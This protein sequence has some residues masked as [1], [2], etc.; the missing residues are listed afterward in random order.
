VT[1]ACGVIVKV[2]Q[3]FTR[4]TG[5]TAG[6]AIGKTHNLLKSGRHDTDFY[7]EMWRQIRETG[8]WQGEIWDKHKNGEHY[9]TRL[10]ISAVRDKSGRV[11][12]YIGSHTNL[13]ER[14]STEDKIRNLAFYDHLTGLPN[15]R[16]LLDRLHQA[17]ASGMRNG[18]DGAL[19]FIDMDNF[20]TL[21][22]TLG[23]DIGD[24]LLQK[25]AIRLKT[26]V[27]EIDTVA[28]IGGD[29]FVVMLEDLNEQTLEAAELA[30]AIGEKILSALNQPYQLATHV[31]HSSVSIGI[32]LFSNQ[33]QEEDP[34][35]QADIAMYQA[36]RD[37]RNKLRFFDQGMQDVIN[38]RAL[39][40][41]QLH[42]ALE[43]QQF[44]LHYQIQMD[45]SNKILGAEALLRWMHPERGMLLPA[46]FMPVAEETGLILS[47]GTWVLE[48]ACAQL[49]IWQQNAGTREMLLSVNISP[50]QFQQPDFAAQ[51][52]KTINRYE[53]NPARLKLELTE[54]M[55]LRNIEETIVTMN[56]LKEIGVQFSLD[57]F[58]T[59]YSSLQY[60]KRLPLAQLKIDQSFVRDLA[61]DKNDQTIVR[62]I[63]AMAHSLNLH[64]IAEGVETI[65][66][67][68]FLLDNG[69]EHFQGYLVG[70]PDAVGQ[71]AEMY[72]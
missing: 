68:Q 63:I 4:T 12:H 64:V 18:R 33:S 15:R 45:S 29:E 7:R 3:A 9:P 27:R 70:R 24:L 51:V 69:C 35:K 66:Q 1:D 43:Q 2:N 11:T 19:L 46:E 55:L 23:H 25:V 22:D 41:S 34:F 38:A 37:G 49:K 72:Q 16:L 10:S 50:R 39:L 67:R 65:E 36:K 20:K 44:H 52:Q 30:E 48:T 42:H 59:G 32:T 28:R 6:E 13:S 71:F 31:F 61:T 8:N 53:I 60:L 54:G 14:K 26:C 56:L 47:L 62:T 17:R 5:Y 21:N 40:E 58:G 57:D